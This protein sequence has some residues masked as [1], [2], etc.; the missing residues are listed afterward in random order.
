MCEVK[1]SRWEI[2][3]KTIEEIMELFPYLESIV[4]QGGEIFLLDYFE[5]IFDEAVKF[6]DLKQTI[7]TNGLAIDERWAQKLA[8]SNIELAYSIDGTTKEVYEHI[9]QGAK[10]ESIIRSLNTI[11]EAK[12]KFGSLHM[13]LR[14]HV[15]IMR[16]NYH[17]L[18]GFID[19]AKEY[20]FDAIHLIPMWGNLNSQEN[21]FHQ[22]DESALGHISAVSNII[23]EKAKK[24]NIQLLNSLPRNNLRHN[25][26]NRQEDKVNC[27]KK[28]EDML[29]C[30]LPWQ[31]LNIDPGGAVRPGCL[32]L[33][34]LGS[35]LEDSL[36]DL[37]NNAVMQNYRK[38]IIDRDY[39]GWCIPQCLSGQIS[40]ELRRV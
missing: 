22:R 4:W 21:I 38:K 8:T 30:Q 26:N 12:M 6:N 20:G 9:R 27:T 19:F 13:S 3:R 39:H 23:E 40:N 29:L 36:K 7:V 11:R 33:K 18:E 34:P 1:N 17:Q 32:C 31:Q 10:F 2:P 16:S 35:I 37:W 5:N 14:M 24:Y 15:V 25:N 28:D